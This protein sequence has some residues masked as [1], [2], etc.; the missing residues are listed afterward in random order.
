MYGRVAVL[1]ALASL[2]LLSIAACQDPCFL[3][4]GCHST[5][6]VAVEGRILDGQSGLAVPGTAVTLLVRTAGNIDSAG[7]VSDER[8][9]FSLVVPL[10]GLAPD[11]VA[12][13]VLPPGKPGYVIS[14]LDCKPVTKWGDACVL[15]PIVT[16][17]SFPLF[18]FVYRSDLARPAAN[19]RVVFTR[20]SGARLVGLPDGGSIEG[21]TDALGYVLLIPPGIYPDSLGA[22]IGEL[23]LDL[24]APLGTTVRQNY[25]VHANPRFNSAD[26]GVQPVGPSLSYVM[27]FTDSVT[28]RGVEGVE[29]RF[30]RRSGIATQINSSV[31]VSIIDGRAFLNLTTFEQGS[32][33]GDFSFTPPGSTRTTALNGV[34]LNTFDAD[35]SIILT[36]WKVGS[37][38]ILYPVSRP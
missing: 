27:V 34:V 13:R 9:L 17:P 20:T 4:A 14:P 26:V 35:S 21:T 25:G 38:G 16:E 28:G 30:E 6:R 10:S 33:T 19:V 7:V 32:I 3:V 29:M 8:G 5:D 37:T 1:P 31:T 23:K 2:G 15:N 24:P 11:S 12:L 22:V 36:R 18:R